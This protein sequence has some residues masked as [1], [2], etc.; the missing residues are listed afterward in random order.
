[1]TVKIGHKPNKSNLLDFVYGEERIVFERADRRYVTDRIKIKVHPD[2]RVVVCAPNG[3]SDSEVLSAVKKRA[4]WVYEKQRDFAA[5]LEYITPRKYVSGESHYYLGKQYQL[6]VEETIGNCSSVKLLR[7]RLE[8]VAKGKFSTNVKTQLDDWYRDNAKRIFER[9]L[10]TLLDSALWVEGRPSIRIRHMATQW[11]SCSKNGL[12]T[13]NP[14]LV[15]A[16][17]ECINYVLLHELCHIAEHNHSERFYRLMSQVMPRWEDVKER[18]DG[19][20][21]LLLS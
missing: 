20:A 7:G 17:V 11:G 16:S 19:M 21:N 2:S 9:Q 14:H 5:H 15:K 1:M 12:I 4:R 3:T 6:K 8:V 13:M 18:L 10:D